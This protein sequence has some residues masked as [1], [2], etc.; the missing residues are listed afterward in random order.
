MD[1]AVPSAPLDATFTNQDGQ[2]ATLSN[3]A[4]KPVFLFRAPVLTS[5]QEERPVTNGALLAFERESHAQHLEPEAA[6]VEVRGR[7]AA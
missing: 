3:F 6:I 2:Q 7:S 1:R 4:G 5:C